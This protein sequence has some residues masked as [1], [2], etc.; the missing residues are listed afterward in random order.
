MYAFD[1]T[2]GA[3]AALGDDEY[4][5]CVLALCTLRAVAAGTRDCSGESLGLF[6][7][8]VHPVLQRLQSEAAGVGESSRERSTS[9]SVW[10]MEIFT[11]GETALSEPEHMRAIC[12][13]RYSS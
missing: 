11:V 10:S 13:A 8:F 4:R 3:S 1:G 2:P 7:L 6:L 9:A 12:A 5:T